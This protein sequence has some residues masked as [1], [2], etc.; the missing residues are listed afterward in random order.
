[1]EKNGDRRFCGKRLRVQFGIHH[2]ENLHQFIFSPLCL[3]LCEKFIF[4]A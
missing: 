3:R 1:M 2:S 4:G